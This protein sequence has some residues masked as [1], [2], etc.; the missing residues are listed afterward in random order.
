[1]T[2]AKDAFLFT[3]NTYIMIF[4]TFVVVVNLHKYWKLFSNVCQA[5]YTGLHLRKDKIILRNGDTK[6][7]VENHKSWRDRAKWISYFE[8]RIETLQ[9]NKA[10][11]PNREN[12]VIVH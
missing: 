1:M 11:R 8:I 12:H 9:E 2:V 3:E 6:W 4:F 5:T 10:P 7:I